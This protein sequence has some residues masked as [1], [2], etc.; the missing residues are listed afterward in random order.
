MTPFK[1]ALITA[2]FFGLYHFNPYGLFALIAL[3][4]YLGYASYLSN[5]IVLPMFL[6]FLNNFIAIMIYF[7]LGN[8]DLLDN[9]VP[10]DVDI[11]LT[12]I[13]FLMLLLLFA[14]VIYLIRRYYSQKNMRNEYAGMS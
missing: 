3:G 2:I 1:A 6:H 13:V 11:K 4:F 7:V 10:A 8:K 14:G 5:S 9:S 12:F